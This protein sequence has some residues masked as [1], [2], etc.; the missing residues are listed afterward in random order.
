MVANMD[1]EKS[2]LPPYSDAPLPSGSRRSSHHHHHHTHSKRWLRPSRSMKLIVLCLGFIAFAQ[3]KQLSFLP[4]SKPSSN[5]SAARLQQDLETCAALRRKPQD[6][7]GLGRKKN[8]RYVEGQRPTLIR[9]ATVWVGEPAEGTSPA[10]DR[11]GKGY[12]WITAD[13]LI[14]YG[15]IQKVEADISLDSLPKDTQVYDA[16]GRQLTSGVIDMHSHA[17]VGAL[18]ELNGNQDVNEMSNDITP[19]VRSIDGLNPLDPQIQV[20]KSGGVTT[21]LVLPGSGNNIGGEAYV[22]KHAVGKPDGRTEFSAE[23]MLADP[24]RNWR[25]MKMACGENAKRVYGKV[26]HSPFSRLGES[27]EF[28]H[29]FEQA[30]KLVREQDDWCDAADKF[31]VESQTQYLPQDLKWESLSA[32]LRGQVHI[33]T[34]CYTIPD[35]EAFVDHTNEF[36]FPVRAFHHAHQTYLVPEILKRTWGGRP[37][38]SALFADNM[39]YKS[40]SY[41]ASEYAGKI[42]WE[43][44]LTPVYVS[45]NPVLNAQHVLFEAAK[46]YK[47]GLPYHAA[48]A[49]VTSAPAELLGLGQRIGKIKP[50]FDADIAV[51]DSDPLSVGAAPV[52]V[53][54]DGAAQFSDPFELDK[55]LTGPIS[56]EPEL[57]NITEEATDLKDVVFTGVANVWLSGEEKSSSAEPVNVVVSDGAIKCIGTCTE[58]VAA[59]KSSSKKIINL[60]N[61][62]ITESFTAFGSSIGLNEIDGEADTDNGRSSGFSRGIDGLALDNKKLHVA[63]RYGVTKA[64]SAP[65]FSGQATHSGTS[66][67][68]NTGA[69]HAFEKDAV[70]GE[71]V[72]LHRTLT[73]AAKRGD[74]P[75]ISGA[76][77]AL[78]HTLLEAV[79]SND[80][81]SDPFSEAVYLK[82]VVNGELPLILTVHSADTIIAILR[83]KSAVEE[84]LAAKS[85]SSESPKLRVGI[86]GGAESHLV[87]TELASAG[88]G[89]V[90]A[91]FQSYSN[92]WDQRRSLTGAPLT[93]GTAIDTLLDAGVVT[94]IGLEE[95]WLIRDLGLL[96]GIA[97]QNGGSRLNGKK[98]LDLVSSNIYKILGVEEPQAKG[99]RHFVVHEGSPLEIGGRVRAVGNGRETVSVFV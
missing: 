12:S 8:A 70:W 49:S 74:N 78:R 63:L 71:D 2:G 18:P 61:G 33:N 15:L 94:A 60:K 19:Y 26:G 52:Q 54:I 77:G 86:I 20:I 16:K 10:D 73:L 25:Y 59:A 31:G 47:Y 93:N 30:A 88:V 98:A 90:L 28:R 55:P 35:L 69:L 34:H 21:S 32:A 92:T 48:L 5:L 58:E 13:V 41:V 1:P 97:Y 40:E 50:G 4:S 81:G 68:F 9:N 17:G 38:A 36:K 80:T 64:I 79:A 29:A 96:A 87:A 23:D 14:D 67:G 84:A 76:I 65:K 46:A 51:W 72:A 95:D 24:D 27:W 85:Q 57:A 83:L 22:I 53:W 82:K 6:P 56:P 43:N 37:P 91:P 7:I 39:Y 3:W 99:S 66:V 45:D 42:L 11:A 75:S 44:G 89:V 62:H